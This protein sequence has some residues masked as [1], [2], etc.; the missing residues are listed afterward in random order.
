MRDIAK[1][2]GVSRQL[3]SLVLRDAPGPSIE[4]RERILA[5]AAELGYRPHASARLLR[6]GRT[7][8]I[9]VLFALRNPFEVRFV[10]QL[11]ALAAK[12]GYGL[13]LG[14]RSVERS[15]DSVVAQ[16]IDQR[17]EAIV[18]FNPDP[19][20]PA[21]QQ[22]LRRIP[23]AWMGERAGAVYADNIHVDE[24]AGFV[25][26]IKHLHSLGHR[27][28]A[29]SGGGGSTVGLDRE[30]AYRRAMNDSDLGQHIDVIASDFSEEDGAAAA[31]RVLA[32]PMP[33]RPTAIICCG[34][35]N[36][37]GVL[38][39]FAREGLGV[40]EEISVVGFDDSYVAAL[41][42]HQLTSIRQDVKAT[43]DAALTV[44]LRRLEDPTKAPQELLTPTRLVVRQT[45]G[46]A[47]I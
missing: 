33:E 38:A 11:E 7:R 3:V 25:L 31:A 8:L 35:L 5:A 9:G 24:E 36:A 22:A 21:L 39:V 12:R 46:P 40:P 14:A 26:A 1:H 6:Q 28:I 16:L 17:V 41:S 10:E 30:A 45:T 47:A 13:V 42:Y 29:Y 19:A 32:R 37:V 44:I 20:S 27:R 15:N 2:V 4:S 43:A 18:A 23:V 34:D